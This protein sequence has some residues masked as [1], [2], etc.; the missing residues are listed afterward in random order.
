MHD[1]TRTG[2]ERVAVMHNAAIVPDHDVAGA[3]LMAPGELWLRRMAPQ[4]VEKVL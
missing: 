4:R 1:S 3:P 2:I